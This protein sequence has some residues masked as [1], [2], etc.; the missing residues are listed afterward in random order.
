MH[1]RDL[2]RGFAASLTLACGGRLY[3]APSSPARFLLV[4]LR[5]GYDA[6][7]ALVPYASDFYRSARPNLAIALPRRDDET[8]A[9]R[10]DAEWAL[11][12]ALRASMAPMYEAGQVAFVP[13]AGTP[14]LSRSHFETQAH[15]EAGYG[16]TGAKG[17]RTGFLARL[18]AELDGIDAM[19][20]T[21][22]LPLAFE[23]G[24]KIPNL[25]LRGRLRAA[26]APAQAERIV[27]LY[28][29]DPLAADVRRGLELR[30]E[31]ASE[32]AGQ[33]P[34]ASRGALG[35]RGFER[36]A[37]RIG[38]LMRDRYRLGFVD[39]GGWDT[40]VNQG[41]ATGLLADNLASLGAGLAALANSL[42]DAWAD[43]V[44]VVASEFGR[45]FRE[46]GNRGTDHGHGTTYWILGG[47]LR[48]GR[49]AGE[50]VAVERAK[51][52]EDR[53]YRVL[54]DAR[55]LHAGLF[56][57]LWGLRGDALDRVLP[58]SRPLDL[59]LL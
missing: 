23:G 4:F 53:D 18:A 10:L 27:A 33:D 58:G 13:F 26:V 45:T 29:D 39:V 49:I 35:V 6:N 36:E 15:F 9:L 17:R 28:G 31:L 21:D 55:D 50:Q 52:L 37:T 57:R 42:G 19:A 25:S 46:N 16:D 51:L 38:T 48:G 3:A 24:P 11:A 22:A 2:L 8:S 14:D 43:T 54:N 41:G 56:A 40:H 44:V 47:G 20:F 12:P 34:S 30:D 32:F 59:R 7:A 5:G 1:R